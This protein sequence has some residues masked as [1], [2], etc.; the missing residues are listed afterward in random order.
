MKLRPKVREGNKEPSD[1]GH[2]LKSGAS[3]TRTG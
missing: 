3:S 2:S 1:D